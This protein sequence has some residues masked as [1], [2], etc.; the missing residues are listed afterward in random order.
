MKKAWKK[1]EKKKKNKREWEAAYHRT[2]KKYGAGQYLLDVPAKKGTMS[3][4]YFN[5][6][7]QYIL[8]FY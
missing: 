7:N 6:V 1:I 2:Y 8:C 5:D 4:S 3:F